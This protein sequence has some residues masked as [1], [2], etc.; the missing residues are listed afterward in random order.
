ME[1]KKYIFDFQKI[2]TTTNKYLTRG[3]INNFNIKW[4]KANDEFIFVEG[5][6]Q[7]V[8]DFTSGILVNCLGYKNE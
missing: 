7:K 6:N 2:Q 4:E 1:D 3:L 5:L 8:I